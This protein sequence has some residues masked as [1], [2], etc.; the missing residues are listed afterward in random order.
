MKNSVKKEFQNSLDITSD[1]IENYIP[2]LLKGLWELGSVP[3][4]IIELIVRNNLEKNKKII[5]LG[6]GK[7]AVLVKLAQRFDIRAI[8]VDIVADFI[9]EANIYANKYVVSDKVKFKTEDITETL[10]AT[11]NHDIVIY[12]YDSEI[13]GDL[14]NSLK[15][16]TN[17]IKKDGY[18][19]LEFMFADQPVDGIVTEKEMK[20]IIEQA[21]YHILDRI[22]WNRE[23]LKQTNQHN[24]KIIKQNV[25]RLI[26]QYPGK[27]KK[28]NE[29]LLKQIEECIEL[30]NKYTCTTLLLRQKN[31]CA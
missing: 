20:N 26:S 4:Y 25:K 3:A 7:G 24:T 29:Y 17:C 14:N 8:G 11:T 21:G 23:T 19:L 28:F 1:E 5:D 30:E 15:E 18:I 6:C 22:D 27:K 12:G 2:E 10:K 16:L 13:L 9:E 31:Y